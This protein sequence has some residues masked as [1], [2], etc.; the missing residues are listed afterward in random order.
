MEIV[1]YPDPR[2]KEKVPPVAEDD[3]DIE[4]QAKD[5]LKFMKK[6]KGAGLSGPQIG[7]MKQIIVIQPTPESEEEVFLNPRIIKRKGREVGPEGCLSFPGLF[8]SVTRAIKITFTAR[9]LSGEEVTLE[10]EGFPAKVV[11]HEIDHL[12]GMVFI[13]KAQPAEQLLVKRYLKR[14]GV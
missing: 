11:Q 14:I 10:K 2:L 6:H 5:M 9:L 4:K 1:T 12:N 8:V 3:K 7:I 13:H